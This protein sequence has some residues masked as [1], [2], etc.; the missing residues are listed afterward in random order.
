MGN[1]IKNFNDFINEWDRLIIPFQKNTTEVYQGW[2]EGKKVKKSKSIWTDGTSI[3]SYGT[4]LLAYE[5]SGES[6]VVNIT[7]YS[8]TTTNHVVTIL[9][10]LVDKGIEVIPVTDMEQD[11]SPEALLIVAGVSEKNP[12]FKSKGKVT[13]LDGVHIPRTP[14]QVKSGKKVAE[15]PDG[16]GNFDDPDPF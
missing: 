10:Y 3:Y 11:V 15:L 13:T 7:P 5:G 14:E 8:D 9:R 1:H 16:A 2:H 12:D 4:A 6:V